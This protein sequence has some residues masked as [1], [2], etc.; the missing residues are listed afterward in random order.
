MRDDVLIDAGPLVALLDRSD[1]AHARCQ[2]V[3]ETLTHPPLTVWP[4]LAEAS[5][6][7]SK[8][9]LG[10]STLLRLLQT[11]TVSIAKLERDDVGRMYELMAKYRDLPMDLADAAIVRVAERERINRVFTIDQK[12]F[13]IYRPA[14]IRHF[15][16]LP[17]TMFPA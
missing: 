5:Y 11:G 2:H 1:A 7:L 13:R 16:L 17:S 12:D 3:L 15:T 14:H 9:H 10:Q 6:L 4:A 8:I